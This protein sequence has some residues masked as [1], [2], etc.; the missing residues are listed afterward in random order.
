MAETLPNGLQAIRR[1]GLLVND[2]LVAQINDRIGKLAVAVES[3]PGIDVSQPI[4]G[5]FVV[6]VD[7]EKNDDS[8]GGTPTTNGGGG[9]GSVDLDIIQQILNR[10]TALES[11]APFVTQVQCVD[12]EIEVTTCSP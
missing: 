2:D 12:G 5:N 4:P 8:D 1:K 10:L 3:G 6:G 9:G 11:C 7:P